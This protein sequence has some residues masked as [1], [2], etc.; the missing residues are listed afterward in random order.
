MESIRCPAA[1]HVAL[2]L[3]FFGPKVIAL[4]MHISIFKGSALAYEASIASSRLCC[5]M[6][7]GSATTMQ[8]IRCRMHLRQGEQS[9]GY[10]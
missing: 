8:R 6:E 7:M 2:L 4:C 9:P 10:W 1:Q 3:S 5:L